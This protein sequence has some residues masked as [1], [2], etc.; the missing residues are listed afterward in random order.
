LDLVSRKRERD[1]LG[2]VKTGRISLTMPIGTKERT[3]AQTRD[4][5]AKIVLSYF[6]GAKTKRNESL[7]R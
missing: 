1:R 2:H 7:L 3:D 4:A 6:S 5:Y